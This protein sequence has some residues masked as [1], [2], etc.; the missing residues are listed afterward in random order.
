MAGAVDEPDQDR[1]G[2]EHQR[3]GMK[4]SERQ[5]R[6]RTRHKGDQRAPPAPREDHGVA[7]ARERRQPKRARS[8]E[9]VGDAERE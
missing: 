9:R 4:R 2:Q 8:G 3:P 7:K 1:K 6:D 5:G